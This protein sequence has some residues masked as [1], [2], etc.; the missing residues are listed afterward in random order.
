M[1]PVRTTPPLWCWF[2]VIGV[3]GLSA[4]AHYTPKPLVPATTAATL[5]SR[6]LADAGLR[7]YIEGNVGHPFEQWP[8]QVW[9]VE[10]LTLAAFY[11]HPSL[12]VV[13]AQWT[14]AAATVITAGARP[15]PTLI[16]TPE[17]SSNPPPGISPWLPSI[18][19][20]LPIE[21][22]GK[23]GF[24]LAQAQQLSEAA[25]WNVL[26]I[27]WQV[28]HNL[29]IALLD[30]TATRRRERL[31]NDQLDIQAEI[32]RLLEQRRTAGAVAG[33][34]VTVARTHLAKTR[35]DLQTARIDSADARVRVADALGVPVAGMGD[36]EFRFSL[37]APTDAGVITTEARARALQRRTD[38][39]SALAEYAAAQFAL[40]LEIAKQYPNVQL[41]PGYQW[42]QGERKWRV[43]L[44]MELPVFN[45]NQ[46]PIAEAE[47]RRAE[48]GARFVALQAN[49]IS[50]IDHATSALRTAEQ[51]LLGGEALLSVQ[52]QQVTSMRSQLAAGAVDSLD[53]ATAQFEL[54]A[55]Q[56][57]A[58][59]A[60]VRRQQSL[61]A[62][63]D[64]LQQP[65]GIENGAQ[66][67]LLQIQST[68]H[69]PNSHQ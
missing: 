33:S 14:T 9:N 45:R 22:A 58:F 61:S 56:V 28:R 43:G 37:E 2:A 16:L 66:T 54:S 42:D 57:L 26:T 32:I 49:V 40:Q 50:D 53:V 65:L 15:N 35:L 34:E 24:R 27:A 12:E 31:L 64:A 41:G 36:V 8:L 60:R 21:T 10:L 25:R 47:A 39:L 17:F 4:C 62:L 6:T 52:G 59:E 67:V 23:R 19:L 44:T 38:V 11:Y 69:S 51:A 18:G 55:V 1:K 13:R 46:G 63:E 68:Q 3:L 5:E 7:A 30:V 20:E 48:V 29:R